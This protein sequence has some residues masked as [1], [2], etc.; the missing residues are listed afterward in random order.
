MASKL[1]RIPTSGG[2]SDKDKADAARLV[3]RNATSPDDEQQLLDELG[4]TTTEDQ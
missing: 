2:N 1:P 3:H 4:L